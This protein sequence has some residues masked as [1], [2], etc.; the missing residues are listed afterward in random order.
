MANS[1]VCVWIS[2]FLY[3]IQEL[4]N[5]TILGYRPVSARLLEPRPLVGSRVWLRG[6]LLQQHPLGQSS[7]HVEGYNSPK[8]AAQTIVYATAHYCQVKG[9]RARQWIINTQS[10]C[11]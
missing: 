10:S 1:P 4:S 8:V 11:L 6:L 3:T 5:T 7:T 9:K 2:K